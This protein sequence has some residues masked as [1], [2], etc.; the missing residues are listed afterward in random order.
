M[1]KREKNVLKHKLR[2]IILPRNQY[3]CCIVTLQLS[4]LQNMMTTNPLKDHTSCIFFFLIRD[5]Q[6]RGDQEPGQVVQDATSGRLPRGTLWHYDDVLEAE[7]WEPADFWISAEH[8]QRL[9]YRHGG[10]IWDAAVIKEKEHFFL[11][12]T[13]RQQNVQKRDVRLDWIED[14]DRGSSL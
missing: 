10:T 1:K 12:V 13:P 7:A 3:K 8:S 4:K 2:F 14:E 5:D 9:L 11:L 6:P